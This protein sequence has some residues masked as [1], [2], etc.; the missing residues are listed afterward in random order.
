[1]TVYQFLAQHSVDIAQIDWFVKN[2]QQAAAVN[3]FQKATH[4]DS[5]TSQFFVQNYKGIL[6]GE[7]PFSVENKF[8]NSEN[9]RWKTSTTPNR[10][11]VFI[12]K[13]K[14]SFPFLKILASVLSV[15][16]LALHLTQMQNSRPLPPLPPPDID[17]SIEDASFDHYPYPAA[18]TI[19]AID[20]ID[21]YPYPLEMFSGDQR[22]KE[23]ERIKNA[24]HLLEKAEKYP[25][26]AQA[27]EALMRYF[28][29][30]YPEMLEKNNAESFEAFFAQQNLTFKVGKC[31]KN[32]NSD[33]YRCVSCMVL[34]YNTKEKDWDESPEG[35]NFTR[36]AY[37]FYQL[38][39]DDVWSARDLSMTIPYDYE[40]VKKYQGNR[41]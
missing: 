7:I 5:V 19:A 27:E 21:H 37:D 1:M 4:L 10:Q 25:T 15:L 39:E 40:F 32:L 3:Y 18:D 12:D 29:E 35:D 9:V 30:F 16:G 8:H 11:G 26:D 17:F 6:S 34:L 23:L 31:Y 28:Y 20:A 41:K 24:I 2:N 36:N 22:E 14:K 38:S 33:Y 13:N